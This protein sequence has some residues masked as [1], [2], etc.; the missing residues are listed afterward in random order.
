MLCFTLPAPVRE[1]IETLNQAGH[2]AYLVGG[3]VRDALRGQLPHDYDITTSAL[4]AEVAACFSDKTI[5][6]TG[7]KH[8]TLTLHSGG[9]D[10]EITTFRTDGIYE[11]HRHPAMI[12]FAPTLQEDLARRDFTINAMAYHPQTGLIDLFGGRSDLEHGILRCVGDPDT[13]FGEDALRILRALRFAAVLDFAIDAETARAL[14]SQKELLH[15]ISS[16]RIRAEL[17]RLLCGKAADTVLSSYFEVLTAVLPELLPMKGFA[18]KNPHHIYD[19]WEHTIA[20]IQ[21]VPPT[22][23]LRL[24]A[25]LHD[26]GKPDCFTED[27]NGIGHFYQHDR[28]GAEMTRRILRRLKFDNAT[29]L[30]VVTLVREHGRQIEPSA[31]AVKRVLRRFGP[32]MFF[33]LIALKRADAAGQSPAFASR[34]GLYDRLEQIAADILSQKQCFCRKDLAVTGLDLMA[35]GLP[36]G[37]ELGLALDRLLDAVIDEKVINE[38]DALLHYLLDDSAACNASENR[39]KAAGQG[40]SSP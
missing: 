38:K 35:A 5:I 16:E 39:Q 30:Q 27:A 1:T 10:L 19:V 31:K 32:E 37:R 9:M 7:L 18:Q 13:R 26:I 6:E 23:Q 3:C 28:L 4:P 22:P 21:A 33:D 40:S 11:D 24:A 36:A 2:E 25:L 8:G 20:V 34:Q 15:V 29:T 14:F 17:L 12:R